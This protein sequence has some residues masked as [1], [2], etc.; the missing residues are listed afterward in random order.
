[1]AVEFDAEGLSIAPG[2]P[3]V[4]WS[5]ITASKSGWDGTQLRLEWEQGG[6]RVAVVVSESAG[7]A[8]I[9]GVAA[10]RTRRAAGDRPTRA[11]SQAIIWITFILPI[12]LIGALVSQHERIIG[13][14]VSNISVEQERRLG[15]IAFGQQKAQLKLVD[16]PAREMAAS[17]VG[18]LSA[19]SAYRY[20]VHVADDKLVNAFAMPGGF[21]VVNSGLIKAAKTPEEIAGV[22]AHEIAHVEKRHSL[23]AIAQSLGLT[24]GLALV[25]GDASGLAS[26]G[27]DLM[28]LGF[29]RAN[30]LEADREGFGYLV[31]AKIR[32]EGMREFF[33]RMAGER[34][35]VPAIL[36]THPAGEDRFT[37]ID[38]LIAEAPAEAR[39]APA[40]SIDLPAIQ[41]SLP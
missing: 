18:R 1:M 33:K 12:L 6:G 19:G 21:V 13:W 15:E 36:S 5:L 20:E 9:G 26:M 2:T 35:L 16:G 11:W 10:N 25:L 39:E 30:E 28:R 37:A 40:L 17:L 29:S 23:R 7:I 24:A 41:K 3:R 4:A 8:K 31:K 27:A 34:Q 32:P 38:R 14:A 22:L